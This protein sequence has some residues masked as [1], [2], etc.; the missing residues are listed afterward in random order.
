MWVCR[1]ADSKSTYLCH[2]G[3]KGQKWGIRNGPPYP[4]KG[5]KKLNKNKTLTKEKEDDNVV[6]N[7][8]KNGEVS[9]TINPEKQRRHTEKDHIQGRSYLYGDNDYAQELVD[10]Y[11]GT[12]T[13][14]KNRDGKWKN[15]ELVKCDNIIG[16]Y[17]DSNNNSKESSNALIVYS[18]TGAHIYPR[19]PDIDE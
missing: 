3:I 9:K 13:V 6:L 10:K 2:H 19:R 1:K 18:K 7:A 4:I 8:I 5:N 14:M 16:L 17:I 15:K 11:A 12:G